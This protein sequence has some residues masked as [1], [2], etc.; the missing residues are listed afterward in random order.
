[1]NVGQ[2]IQL[3]DGTTRW[4]TPTG[5]AWSASPVVRV[6]VRVQR[7]LTY[8]SSKSQ[9]MVEGGLLCTPPYTG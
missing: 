5:D 9:Y 2:Q 1:V 8:S 4:R 6:S 3:L 7:V